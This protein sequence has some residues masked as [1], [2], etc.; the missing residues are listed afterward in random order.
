MDIL[1]ALEVLNEAFDYLSECEISDKRFKAINEAEDV[2]NNFVRTRLGAVE[3][4][5]CPICG[6]ELEYDDFFFEDCDGERVY[7]SCGGGCPECSDTYSWIETYT[8]HSI[9]D[10]RKTGIVA[11]FFPG[12]LEN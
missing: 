5:V 9:S 3:V 12:E 6:E 11:P 1:K 4:P 7:F 2:I 8:L 10:L